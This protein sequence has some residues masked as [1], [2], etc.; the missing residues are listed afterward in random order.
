VQIVIPMAGKSQ[1]FFDVGYNQPKCLIE[2]FGLPM[3]GHILNSFKNFIDVLVIVNEEDYVK[4]DLNTVVSGLHKTAKVVKIKQHSLGPSYSIL[5]SSEFINLSKKIIVH[6]CDFSGA[7]DPYDTI[8]L[9][10]TYDGVFVSFTGFHPSR[11]NGTKFA[12]GRANNEKSL[13]EIRE[14][15]SFTAR[16]EDEYASSGIY[17]FSTGNLMLESIVEQVNLK[18]QINGEFYTSLTHE[19]ML[20]NNKK[21]TIQNMNLF[22]A[23]GTPEDLENYIYYMSICKNINEFADQ[24][25]P[26]INHSG[27]IL[28]AGKSSRLRLT[29]EKPKQSKLFAGKNILMDFSKKLILQKSNTYLVATSEIY[30]KNIWNLPDTNLEILTHASESQIATV[31]IGLELVKDREIP[32]TFLASDNIMFFE[33]EKQLESIISTADMLVWTCGN[34][35]FAKVYPEQYSW[36]KINDDNT[37][38]SAVYKESPKELRNWKLIT[39]NFT[40]RNHSIVST[41]IKG[42]ES[43]IGSLQREPILDDLVGVALTM[44][45]NVRA[46]DVSKY[47]TLGSHLENKMF[48]YY[49]EIYN[50]EY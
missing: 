48:D 1:R 34:Y 29:G 43:Q 19:V 10:N 14:K 7:W 33:D 27:V 47:I 38:E 11:I 6:Y 17:G 31:Q 24:N 23:W 50:Y 28:A 40:F 21:I 5:K 46:F 41:L 39:G 44:G 12:Y 32:I 22:Y 45:Y 49:N 26:I 16:P 9:L 2:F 15:G 25:T 36:V 20:R 13:L 35:P 8:N 3:I 30:S 18:L 37:I 42:L 4:F